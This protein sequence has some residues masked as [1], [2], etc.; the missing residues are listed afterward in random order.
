[1]GAKRLSNKNHWEGTYRHTNTPARGH[2][3]Y[4]IESS[5]W[6]DS[7]K[8]WIGSMIGFLFCF[9]CHLLFVGYTPWLGIF[10]L[11]L[12]MDELSIILK[13]HKNWNFTNNKISPKLI[14][15]QHKN[16]IKTEISPKL[17]LFKT[18]ISPKLIFQ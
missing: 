5:Q 16:V 6:A 8:I 7:V 1:M 4:T 13:C 18:G 3:D 10:K 11:A 15:H 17:K 2:R 12:G 9:F 14:C